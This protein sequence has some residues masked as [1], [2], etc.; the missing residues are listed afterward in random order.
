MTEEVKRLARLL[1]DLPLADARI[2][3]TS[4]PG[5]FEGPT[6]P[7]PRDSWTPR[8]WLEAQCA[9]AHEAWIWALGNDGG[10]DACDDARAEFLE[11]KE[12][13]SAVKEH[14]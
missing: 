12:A 6:R 4:W 3:S 9:E 8:Q 1:A 7:D 10:D 11:I 14:P 2:T 5:V 13:L